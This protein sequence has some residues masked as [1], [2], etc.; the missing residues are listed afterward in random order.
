MVYLFNDGDGGLISYLIDTSELIST[1]QLLVDFDEDSDLDIFYSG[2]DSAGYKLFYYEN[3]GLVEFIGREEVSGLWGGIGKIRAF[4][5]IGDGKKELF[6][7]SGSHRAWN[8]HT[9]YHFYNDSQ[10]FGPSNSLSGPPDFSLDW[11]IDDYLNVDVADIDSDGLSDIVYLKTSYWLY[12]IPMTWTTFRKNEGNGIFSDVSSIGHSSFWGAN[13]VTDINHLVDI[14]SDGDI[15]ALYERKLDLVYYENEGDGEF[16]DFK[17]VS[18]F[19]SSPNSIFAEDM[20]GDG[21][22]DLLSSSFSDNKIAYYENL[23]SAEFAKQ[24]IISDEISDASFVSASDI[25]S[26]GDKDIIAH[27]NK[28]LNIVYFENL[29]N[30][31]YS[32]F[33]PK[34]ILNDRVGDIGVGDIDGDLDADIVV[35]QRNSGGSLMFIT[36][37]GMVL[38]QNQ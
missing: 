32:S 2:K 8:K 16:V 20:D 28:G 29:G 10:G 21:D 14:D 9:S 5:I 26:D 34:V 18:K 31:H 6:L 7:I 27:S 38:F 30:G 3:N 13:G 22:F 1:Q 12:G 19:V 11:A 17:G 4:D 35:S 24:R 33:Q 15:D 25:D 37:L 36:I 23:G